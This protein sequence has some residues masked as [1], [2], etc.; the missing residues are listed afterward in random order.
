M[1][2]R[3]VPQAYSGRRGKLLRD[4][5]FKMSIEDVGIKHDLLL[6]S[7]LVKFTI[8]GLGTD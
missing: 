2:L 1:S 7:F 3:G 4:H 8:L 6:L 5:F